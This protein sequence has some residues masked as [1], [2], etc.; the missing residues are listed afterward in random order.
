MS[1]HTKFNP[2]GVKG[3]TA[4]PPHNFFKIMA[5]NFQIHEVT[6]SIVDANTQIELA[7]MSHDI[8]GR[9]GSERAE[10]SAIDKTKD[11]VLE[12]WA[13]QWWHTHYGLTAEQFEKLAEDGR[14]DPLGSWD[15]KV[16]ECKYFG[17]AEMRPEK[18]AK[19]CKAAS[20][21]RVLDFSEDD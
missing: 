21:K 14:I 11:I 18:Q 6:V 7:R 2:E 13:R 8:I 12:F 10:W 16:V 15:F 20:A 1:T 4:T 9:G 5:A 19:C 3:K 17:E